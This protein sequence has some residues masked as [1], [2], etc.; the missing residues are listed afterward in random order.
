MR[1]KRLAAVAMVAAIGALSGCG[2]SPTP[3]KPNGCCI[4]GNATWSNPAAASATATIPAGVTQSPSPGAVMAPSLGASIPAN[5]ATK[6]CYTATAPDKSAPPY[7]GLTIS[8]ALT[9]TRGVA[10]SFLPG[11]LTIKNTNRFPVNFFTQPPSYSTGDPG[12]AIELLS[13]GT[14]MVQGAAQRDPGMAGTETQVA[15]K[16]G[17]TKTI[18]VSIPLVN[19]DQNTGGVDLAAGTYDARVGIWTSQSTVQNGKFYYW[20]APRQK[21]TVSAP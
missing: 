6:S 5:T 14:M 17:A 19:C 9:T 10:G 7:P 18:G 21:V 11:T 16:A 3:A 15:L 1:R 8:L 2:S 20:Y 12:S 4:S 13:P